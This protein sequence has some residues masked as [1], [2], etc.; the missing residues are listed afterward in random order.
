MKKPSA[1]LTILVINIALFVMQIISKSADFPLTEMLWLDSAKVISQPWIIVTSM[2]LHG[3]FEHILFNMF[4]LLMFGSLIEQ[5]I[6]TKRFYMIYFASGILAAI[7]FVVTPFGNYAVGASGAIMGILGVTIM[8]LPHL[9][10]LFFF[11]IPMSMRTAGIIIAMVDILGVLGVGPGGIANI[12]HLAGLACG[13][14]YGYYLK[15]KKQKVMRPEVRKKRTK[16]TEMSD[17]DIEA[18]LR[19]GRL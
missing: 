7:A 5:R 2:F 19:Y 3:S 11:V 13:L 10:V 9:Q 18:Y 12:S 1:V 4:V 17:D 14:G 8:L 6:G 15:S 16:R